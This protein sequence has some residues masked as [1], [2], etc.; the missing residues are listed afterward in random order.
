MINQNLS[1]HIVC[2]TGSLLVPVR[3]VLYLVITIS[4]IPPEDLITHEESVEGLR[5]YYASVTSPFVQTIGSSIHPTIDVR[6]SLV[7]SDD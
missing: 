2:R 4:M 6:K 1:S 5:I 7:I 3:E